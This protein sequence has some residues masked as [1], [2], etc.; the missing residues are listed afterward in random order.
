MIQDG[1]L[2]AFGPKDA[3]LGKATREVAKGTDPAKVTRER[4]PE[5]RATA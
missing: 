1:K 3:I 5:E 4:S 2:T